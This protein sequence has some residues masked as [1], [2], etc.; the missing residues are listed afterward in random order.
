MPIPV[1]SADEDYQMGGVSS[2]VLMQNAPHAELAA[3]FLHA[4]LSDEALSLFSGDET[5]LMAKKAPT[6]RVTNQ[7]TLKPVFSDVNGI[8]TAYVTAGRRYFTSIYSAGDTA[9]HR[10]SARSCLNPPFRVNLISTVPFGAACRS[11]TSVTSATR[12]FRSP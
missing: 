9:R 1:F 2:L 12:S 8:K 10:H 4:A 3:D 11:G 6:K 5:R 7:Q